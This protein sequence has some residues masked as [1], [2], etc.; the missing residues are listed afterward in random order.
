MAVSTYSLE[1]Y[2]SFIFL[3]LVKHLREERFVMAGLGNI[4]D[5]R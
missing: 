3:F 1:A 4:Y 5:S 2:L